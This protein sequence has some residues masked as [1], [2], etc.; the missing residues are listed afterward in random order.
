[1]V[2]EAM[3]GQC[4]IAATFEVKGGTT[5]CLHTPVECGPLACLLAAQRGRSHFDRGKGATVLLGDLSGLHTCICMENRQSRAGH[6]QITC[7]SY[8]VITCKVTCKSR[9]GHMHPQQLLS[10]VDGL[11]DGAKFSKAT[12]VSMTCH[13]LSIVVVFG[14]SSRPYAAFFCGQEARSEGT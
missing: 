8:Y 13:L 10:A 6:M 7:R 11:N 14:S 12:S 3:A 1:M 2:L 5:F 4:G 9:V